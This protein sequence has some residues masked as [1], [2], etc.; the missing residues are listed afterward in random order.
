MTVDTAA[1][2][3]FF[4]PAS[5]AVVGASDRQERSNNAVLSMRAAGMM[6]YF[7][8]PNRAEAYGERT[9]P[10]LR[11]IGAPVDAVLSLVPATAALRAV[12]DAREAGA[13]GIVVIAGGFGESGPEGAELERR[14]REAAGG[15]PVLG[16]NC[17]GFVS[18]GNGARLSGAPRALEFPAGSIGVVSHSGAMLGSLGLAAAGRGVG[19]SSLISTGNETVLDMAAALEFL[20]DDE[21]TRCI[22][23]VIE[24]VRNPERFFAAVRRATGRRKPIVAL[25]LGRSDRGQEI[26]TSHTGALAGEAWVYDAALRQHGITVASD[27]V[28]LLDR[29]ALLAQI[30][31]DR[32]TRV[33]GL[34]V[35]GLSGGTSALASD[36]CAE[37]GIELPRLTELTDAINAVLPERTTI[38][39][40][41]MTGF[42]M[43]NAE[44]IRQVL[45]VV[46][47]SDQVDAV[48]LQWFLDEA[49]GEAGAAFVEAAVG[50]AKRLDKPVIIGSVEDSH[51]GE[52]AR[53]L[54]SQGVAI[55]R[56]LRAT[57]R[58]LRTMGD[59]QRFV[60]RQAGE[61]A[62]TPVPPVSRP[63]ARPV[64]TDAGLMLPF[65][66]AM[67]VLSSAGI[68]IAPYVVLEADGDRGPL[69]FAPPYVLKLADVPH[70]SDI[71]AVRTGVGPEDFANT[72]AELRTIAREHGAPA[73]VVVQPQVTIDGEAL[74]GVQ[75]QSDLG[76]LVVFGLG[77]IF[78]E[79]LGKVSGRLAP[80][81]SADADDLLDE[82]AGTGVFAGARGR[83]PW[84]RAQLVD[85]LMTTGRLA[86]GA[87]HWLRSMDVNPL[88]LTPQGF[89]ALDALCLVH[90]AT[91]TA[92]TRR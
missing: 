73:R 42:V 31:T 7:V 50:A 69:P 88:A 1:L 2:H 15:L 24:T 61:E 21:D 77:G 45:D 52:W 91:Q 39:P 58:G 83:R 22:A 46:G 71:G 40:L 32:W 29:V 85:V 84:D 67:S 16:P 12:A 17:N 80:L 53:N 37:E 70:R 13:G 54:P 62:P 89:V 8:N 19:Y 87:R 57:A 30:P 81:T 47:G 92:A 25:K 5:V 33:D 49:T 4:R 36:V 82:L 20:V 66:A 86:A 11:S 76:P 23:L 3:R 18:P 43:G 10:D 9:Y 27:L 26:A 14:L 72:V 75:G 34:V 38:N 41:D 74:L 59:F 51:P 63:D 60:Q 28:D 65:D 55:G 90:P 78:V 56:G 6:L 48:V 68:P 44:A 35:A 64:E 79:L